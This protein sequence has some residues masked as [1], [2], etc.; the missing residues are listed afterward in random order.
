MVY[1]TAKKN[2][3][4]KYKK[5]TIIILL[6]AAYFVDWCFRDYS[7]LVLLI[8]E[9]IIYISVIVALIWL[10]ISR[11]MKTWFN[12][13]VSKKVIIFWDVFSAIKIFRTKSMKSI[14]ICN[15][16]PDG[17]LTGSLCGHFSENTPN[18]VITVKDDYDYVICCQTPQKLYDDLE[19]TFKS[20]YRHICF[21]NQLSD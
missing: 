20:Q 13:I 9:K 16:P 2:G 10:M 14:T 7:N 4:K 11:I 19:K 17:K 15:L 8:H 6:I 3:D 21:S 12:I 5:R 1:K 18:V